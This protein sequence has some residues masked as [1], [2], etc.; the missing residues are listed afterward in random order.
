MAQMNYEVVP[1][2]T[3]VKQRKALAVLTRIYT[4]S[5]DLAAS[6][7]YSSVNSAQSFNLG[8][9]RQLPAYGMTRK[10]GGMTL[11]IICTTQI[12]DT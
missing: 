7:R 11:K 2:T 4:L 8:S 10:G 3:K 6:T 1:P 12:S 9:S 5:K